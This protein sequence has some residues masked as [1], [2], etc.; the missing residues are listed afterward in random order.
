MESS[1]QLENHM[2]WYFSGTALGAPPAKNKNKNKTVEF[3]YRPEKMKKHPCVYIKEVS[4][5]QGE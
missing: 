1:I 2:S 3:E 5:K 4:S